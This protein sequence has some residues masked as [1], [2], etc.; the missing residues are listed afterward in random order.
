MHITVQEN[1]QYPQIVRGLVTEQLW[2]KR[3][4]HSKGEGY[5]GNQREVWATKYVKM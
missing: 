3:S 2:A 4:I 5:Q 1:F